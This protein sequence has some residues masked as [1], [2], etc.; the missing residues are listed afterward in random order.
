MTKQFTNS[1]HQKTPGDL[2]RFS[3]SGDRESDRHLFTS[4][5]NTL[6]KPFTTMAM[7]IRP[8]KL[9][10]TNIQYR[11][12]SFSGREASSHKRVAC[13]GVIRKDIMQWM[14]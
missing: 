8:V 10:G 7:M 12:L 14:L 9:A 11:H 1:S 13:K 5:R 2:Q 6:D 3:T 4:S